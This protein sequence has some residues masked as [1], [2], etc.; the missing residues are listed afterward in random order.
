[1]AE[2]AAKSIVGT[3]FGTK[4]EVVFTNGAKNDLEAVVAVET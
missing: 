1:M 3:V 2:P 4:V